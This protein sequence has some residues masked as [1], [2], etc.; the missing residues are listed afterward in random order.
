MGQDQTGGQ[1]VMLCRPLSQQATKLGNHTATH[2]PIAPAVI[3]NTNNIS[4]SI[5][6]SRATF[7]HGNRADAVAAVGVSNNGVGVSGASVV[8]WGNIISFNHSLMILPKA[9]QLYYAVTIAKNA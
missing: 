1:A 5:S 8:V 2:I 6:K 7:G 9:N 3:S 4:A